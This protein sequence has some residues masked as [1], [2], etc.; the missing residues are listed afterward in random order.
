MAASRRESLRAKQVSQLSDEQK[1]AIFGKIRLSDRSPTVRA[2]LSQRADF[3]PITASP[4]Q[5]N[6]K[7]R[8]RDDFLSA[9]DRAADAVSDGNL[10]ALPSVALARKV[11]AAPPF[12][13]NALFGKSKKELGEMLSR[14][15]TAIRGGSTLKEQVRLPVT[16]GH[17]VSDSV[18]RPL[19][20]SRVPSEIAEAKFDRAKFSKRQNQARR[21]YINYRTDHFTPDDIG[22]LLELPLGIGMY[23]WDPASRRGP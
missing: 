19:L 12:S 2:V 3:T 1:A 14:R 8:S 4:L 5:F 9:I 10:L 20:F 16:G 11:R 13:P 22:A 17:T 18:T 23:H 15:R 6:G 21:E 7:I